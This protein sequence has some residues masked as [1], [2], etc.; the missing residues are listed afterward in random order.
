MGLT[1]KLV[2]GEDVLGRFWPFGAVEHWQGGTPGVLQWTMKEGARLRLIGPHELW[3]EDVN[4]MDMVVQGLS[5]DNEPLTL[6]GACTQRVALGG[7]L[8]E[9]RAARVVGEQ[10]GAD[11][12]WDGAAVRTANLHEWWPVTGFA[13]GDDEFGERGVTRMEVR[14]SAQEAIEIVVPQARIQ[15]AP[16]MS[17]AWAHAPDWS[18]KTDLE[19]S[20]VPEEPV[21]VDAIERRF[22]RRL[23]AFVVF[24]SARPDEATHGRVWLEGEVAVPVLTQRRGLEPREWRF[25]KGYLFVAKDVDDI[26][27]CIRRWLEMYDIAEEALSVFC[28][29]LNEGNEWSPRRHVDLVTA[30]LSYGRD[31]RGLARGGDKVLKGLRDGLGTGAEPL[32]LSDFDLVLMN[33]TRN[34]YAHLGEPTIEGVTVDLIRETTYDSARKATALMQ[35]VLL[36]DLG[37]GEHRVAELMTRHYENWPLPP[38]TPKPES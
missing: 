5:R 16:R 24:A 12:V 2:A 38:S 30:L 8:R 22:T 31:A 23:V 1:E 18:I 4:V 32:Q 35:A 6:L 7:E 25:G 19:F 27:A 3:P 28:G 26:A 13:T 14:W 17:T 20:I 36:Q 29:T 33:A 11:D 37:F 15:L 9:L 34:Y 21:T 10:I